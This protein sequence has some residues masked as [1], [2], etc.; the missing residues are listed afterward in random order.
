MI[1]TYMGR[2]NGEVFTKEPWDEN[3]TAMN[4]LRRD[5]GWED[6]GPMVLMSDW[7]VRAHW[8]RAFEILAD[9]PVHGQTWVLLRRRDVEITVADLAEPR[10]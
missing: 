5:Q 9:A 8:G 1:A 6:G 3:G 2:Y 4:V 7:W 10:R